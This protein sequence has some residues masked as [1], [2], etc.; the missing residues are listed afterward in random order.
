[1]IKIAWKATEKIKLRHDHRIY[2]PQKVWDKLGLNV[3]DVYKLKAQSK[4][5]IILERV[6]N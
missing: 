3:N 6:D 1:M 2:I 5:I 4:D